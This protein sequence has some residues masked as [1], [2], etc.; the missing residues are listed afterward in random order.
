[1][2]ATHERSRAWSAIPGPAVLFL[3]TPPH[4]D[5]GTA[6]PRALKLASTGSKAPSMNSRTLS[7]TIATGFRGPASGSVIKTNSCRS[8]PLTAYSPTPQGVAVGRTT[9]NARHHDLL[10]SR[11]ARTGSWSGSAT[12]SVTPFGIRLRR[13]AKRPGDGRAGRNE[14]RHRDARA[15]PLVCG[16]ASVTPAVGLRGRW[17]RA[18]R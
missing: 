17:S 14:R 5:P 15:G 10:R 7:G 8:D 9:L 18:D 1:M 6:S 2:D 12:C 4:P 11:R 3:P 13:V 16:A